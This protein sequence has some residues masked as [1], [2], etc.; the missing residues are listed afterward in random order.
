VNRS[1]GQYCGLAKALDVVG[2]RW[3]LLVVRELLGGPRRF[4]DLADGL[5]GIGTNV[6]SDRLRELQEGEVIERRTLPPPAGSTVY[7]LTERGRE[8]ASAVL[9]LA[10]WGSELL[11]PRPGREAFR[12]YWLVLTAV[13]ELAGRAPARM[14]LSCEIQAGP[15]GIAHIR[16]AG[17]RVEVGHGHAPD[18]DV[19]VSGSP[20]ELSRLFHAGGNGAGERAAGRVEVEG[21]RKALERLLGAL[22]H[23]A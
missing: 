17:G 19:I 10:G 1:Y 22:H 6:L 8:L 18:P 16:L 14:R 12:A 7:L 3:A 5:P 13:G 23:A 11:G 21:D 4:S 9:D 20:R 15:G 2:G